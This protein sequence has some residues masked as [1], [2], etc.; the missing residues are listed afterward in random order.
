MGK[1]RY[2]IFLKN[3]NSGNENL[4]Y[5]NSWNL[6]INV[7]CWEEWNGEWDGSISVSF[8]TI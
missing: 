2:V 3:Q 8:N 1:Q 4:I 6:F 7:F 5:E